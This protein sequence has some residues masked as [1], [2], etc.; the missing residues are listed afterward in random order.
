MQVSS[1]FKTSVEVLLL[2]IVVA[3]ISA[4]ALGVFV[5]FFWTTDS[6]RSDAFYGAFLG[7]FFAFLFVR[8]GNALTMMYERKAKARCALVQLVHKFSELLN[9]VH[10]NLYLIRKL[11]EMEANLETP[12]APAPIYQPRFA[13]HTQIGDILISLGNIDLINELLDLNTTIRKLND[14][15][16]DWQRAHDRVTD[17]FINKKV[18]EM[19]YRAYLKDAVEA[20]QLLG[21]FLA[22]F[23]TDLI[24][25]LAAVHVLVRDDT[26]L[27]KITRWTTRDRYGKDFER[28]REAERELILADSRGE[29]PGQRSRVSAVQTVR[30]ENRRA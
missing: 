23:Q 5:D 17:A 10:D 8:L 24:D 14:S 27:G 26:T 1:K 7:A 25:S 12:G 3:F 30:S 15:L 29:S 13:T 2:A 4:M 28:R 19:T 16:D 18:D 6:K 22:A 20:G 21:K 9:I 11:S